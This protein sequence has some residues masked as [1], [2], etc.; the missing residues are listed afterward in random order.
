[1]VNSSTTVEFKM[2]GSVE[3][4]KEGKKSDE[5]KINVNNAHLC[6]IRFVTMHARCC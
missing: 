2:A 5:R 1:M 4:E 6:V 3:E